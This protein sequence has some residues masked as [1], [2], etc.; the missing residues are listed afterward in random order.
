MSHF[1]FRFPREGIPTSLFSFA[2][3]ISRTAFI[4]FGL[5]ISIAVKASDV[6]ASAN[7][8]SCSR[9]Q[10]G[11]ISDGSYNNFV[12]GTVEA[13]ASPEISTEIF[14]WAKQ[15]NWW[16]NLPKETEGFNKSIKLVSIRTNTSD[17]VQLITTMMSV[18][19]YEVAPFNKGDLVRY[20]PHGKHYSPP[21]NSSQ[22]FLS[23]WY[24]H[25]CVLS[26]CTNGDTACSNRYKWGVYNRDTGKEVDVKNSMPLQKGII[27]DTKTFFPITPHDKKPTTKKHNFII[28]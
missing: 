8:F 12:V 9:N 4:I 5:L 13:V 21:E 28:S 22:A 10:C 14:T 2:S 19:E 25:G 15:N 24:L 20:S 11:L 6:E 17:G 7:P 16:N 23:Y 18:E 26:L 1:N 3:A 27:I